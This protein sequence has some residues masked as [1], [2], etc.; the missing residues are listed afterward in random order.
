MGDKKMT[1]GWA[2][3]LIEGLINNKQVQVTS[4]FSKEDYQE[5][6]EILKEGD[7]IIADDIQR[8]YDSYYT[9]ANNLMAE[10]RAEIQGLK[11]NLTATKEELSYEISRA[12]KLKKEKEELKKNRCSNYIYSHGAKRYICLLRLIDTVKK[13]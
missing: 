10:L 11:D 1:R 4:G 7:N 9:K 8:Q 5:A 6:L 13:G 3:S 12:D 2:E